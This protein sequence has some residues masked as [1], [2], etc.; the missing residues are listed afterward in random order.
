[1]NEIVD[2]FA[3]VAAAER[4][5]EHLEQLAKLVERR[6]VDLDLI[7][8]AP[9]ERLVCQVHRLQVCGENDELVKGDLN[10]ATGRQCQVVDPVLQR[11]DP[12][13]EQFGRID[14][15]PTEVVDQ[16]AAAIALQLQRCLAHVR[17]WIVANLETVHRQ[18]A[19]DDDCRALNLDPP[20]IVRGPGQGGRFV[21]SNRFMEGSVEQL[22]ELAVL[23]NRVGQPYVL[24]EAT[25]DSLGE[26]C[27][28]VAGCDRT[29][30]TPHRC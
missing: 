20:L 1:M 30:T 17:C 21:F 13:I 19:T 16:Q 22:N 23:D 27:L 14:P 24:A 12:A 15:L 18:F 29:G 6:I 25:R 4:L 5:A 28:A 9:Q 10:L 8:N 3:A 26:C 2:R 11:H 7:G